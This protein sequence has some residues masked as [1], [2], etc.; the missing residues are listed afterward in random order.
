MN[1][2]VDQ[3]DMDAK[4]LFSV[5]KYTLDTSRVEGVFFCVYGFFS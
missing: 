5:G 1:K 3:Q 4:S 2:M